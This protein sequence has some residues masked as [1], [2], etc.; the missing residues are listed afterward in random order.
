MMMKRMVSEGFA[1]E[2]FRPSRF[3]NTCLA[4]N[5]L[6]TTRGRNLPCSLPPKL[7]FPFLNPSLFPFPFP[8]QLRQIYERVGIYLLY[9]YVC[10]VCM[11]TCNE[12]RNPGTSHRLCLR[13]CL[14]AYPYLSDPYLRVLASRNK[15]SSRYI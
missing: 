12:E 4:Q 7:V 3:L 1:T 10:Y 8:T 2:N 11:H 5:P 15:S 13:A 14:F 9:I 6:P